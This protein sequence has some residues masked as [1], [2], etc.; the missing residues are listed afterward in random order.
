MVNLSFFWDLFCTL[1]SRN[2]FTR[3]TKSPWL[4]FSSVSSPS[5]NTSRKIVCRNFRRRLR[6]EGSSFLCR[7][8]VSILTLEISTSQ[9]PA[10]FCP[11]ALDLV[12][13]G[14]AFRSYKVLPHIETSRCLFKAANDGYTLMNFING[15]NLFTLQYKYNYLVHKT[16]QFMFRSAFYI[17]SSRNNSTK[18]IT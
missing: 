17:I 15:L 10:S 7:K 14:L 11:F 3:V 13:M 12:I 6:H 9:G 2:L 18:Y 1:L 4:T 5:K 8:H 16:L